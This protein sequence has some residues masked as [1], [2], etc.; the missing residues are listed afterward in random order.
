ME[1]KLMKKYW[2]DLLRKN[3]MPNPARFSKDKLY[4]REHRNNFLT[5]KNLITIIKTKSRHYVFGGPI[6][7]ATIDLGDEVIDITFVPPK[8][9]GCQHYK[10]EWSKIKELDFHFL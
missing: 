8:F 7:S 1:N 2:G 3:L 5:S 10:I 6:Y 4:K 9:S